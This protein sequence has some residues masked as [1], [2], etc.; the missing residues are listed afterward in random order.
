MTASGRI[1][2]PPLAADDL[3]ACP[4]CRAPL[5]WRADLRC[6]AC[7]R[8][9]LGSDGVACF[10]DRG[11]Y[12]GPIPPKPQMRAAIELARTEGY[13]AVLAG[14]LSALDPGFVRYISAEERTGGL[15][16]MGLS[17]DERILDFGCAFGNFSV[18]LARRAQLVV[19]LDVTHEKLEFLSVVKQQ[20]DLDNLVPVCNGDPLRLPFA[21]AAFDWVILNAVFEYLPQAIDVADVR[22]AHLLALKEMHRVLRPGGRLYLA[23]KNR[24]SYRSVLGARDHDRLRFTSLLPRRA[25]DALSRARGNGP[26]RIVTHSLRGYARLLDD[27][28]FRSR[29]FRWPL[30]DLWYPD[31]FVPLDGSRAELVRSLRGLVTARTLKRAAWMAAARLGVLPGLVPHY[32]V[33]AEK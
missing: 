10:N 30:P 5:S 13:R 22:E 24:F 31:V 32:V 33:I 18:R 25:A 15:E 6:A 19:A 17:G 7:G 27:A 26:Y 4:A 29:Y 12:H 28:R 21:D 11:T 2:R 3:L 9:Y 1:S 16:L 20:D 23:T 14:Y 8:G